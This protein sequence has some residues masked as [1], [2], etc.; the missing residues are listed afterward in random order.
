MYLTRHRAHFA[1]SGMAIWGEE[2][3]GKCRPRKAWQFESFQ[4]LDLED[5]TEYINDLTKTGIHFSPG[6]PCVYCVK[7]EY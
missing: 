1:L 2:A 4:I 5:P 6:P 3:I 7:H